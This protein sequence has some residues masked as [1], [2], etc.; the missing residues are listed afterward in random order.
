MGS[1]HVEG[2][3]MPVKLAPV[4]DIGDRAAGHRGGPE[5]ARQYNVA[6]LFEPFDI[7]VVFPLGDMAPVS[8]PAIRRAMTSSR[9]GSRMSHAKVDGRPPTPC[10]LKTWIGPRRAR[11][12][13]VILY[14]SGRVL[15]ARTAPGWL[16]TRSAISPDLPVR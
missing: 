9:H 13:A 11:A 5:Q 3:L 7:A 6:L 10:G 16:R 15:V 8:H 14:T 2:L 1:E 12:A 4:E